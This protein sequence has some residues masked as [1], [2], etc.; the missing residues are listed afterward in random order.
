MGGRPPS[1]IGFMIRD[2]LAEGGELHVYE[3]ARRVNRLRAQIDLRA[4]SPE[5]VKRLIYTARD[6]GLI[7]FVGEE[8]KPVDEQSPGHDTLNYWRFYELA[9]GAGASGDWAV[10]PRIQADKI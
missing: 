1:G 3:I 10:L 6:A 9:P 4:A 5:Y 7:E 8:K 2:V